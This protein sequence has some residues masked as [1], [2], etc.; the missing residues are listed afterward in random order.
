MGDWDEE[1]DSKNRHLSDD[2]GCDGS[3]MRKFC[4]H[5]EYEAGEDEDW[6]IRE[7]RFDEDWS[8]YDCR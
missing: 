2:D 8:E 1:A 5:D 3:R 4:G 7:D 6:E